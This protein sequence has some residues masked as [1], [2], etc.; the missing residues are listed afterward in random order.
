MP[1]FWIIQEKVPAGLGFSLFHLP[2][3]LWMGGILL[4]VLAVSI[5]CRKWK[6][7][8]VRRLLC[9]LSWSMIVLELGKDL[10]LGVTHQFRP[11][12]L[13]LDLCGISIWIEFAAVRKPHPLLLELVYSLSLP[14]ACL[15]LLFPN[16]FSLPLWNFYSLHSFLLHGVLVMIP[17]VLLARHVLRPN[18]KRL[19][20]CFGCLAAMSI[21]IAMV[22]RRFGT[23]FFFL[24]RPSA[25][26]PLEWFGTVFGNYR[27]G[28]PVLMLLI[29]TG[30]YGIP[31]LVRR[32]KT[33][34]Q[35]PAN[36]A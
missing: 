25:G 12:Y 11:T 23:N 36:H 10:I 15:A 17:A 1:Y 2:H 3:L 18:W 4:A 6:E 29:W 32:W 24:S 19:P 22:N 26:S 27:I 8:T 31:A 7:T 13:P 30:M 5:S 35:Q 34:K 28:L 14:G 33:K 21:P 20:F 9:I 16:W